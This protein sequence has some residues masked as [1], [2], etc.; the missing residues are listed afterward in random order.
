MDQL[1][2]AVAPRDRLV[3]GRDKEVV[4][5][6]RMIREGRVSCGQVKATGLACQNCRPVSDI[7]KNSCAACVL[8]TTAWTLVG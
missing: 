8:H 3:V 2:G 1:E 7:V 6:T 4:H 5:P